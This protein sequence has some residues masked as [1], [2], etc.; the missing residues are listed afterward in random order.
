MAERA[1]PGLAMR[2]G[3]LVLDHANVEDLFRRR[4]C[5]EERPQ[6]SPGTFPNSVEDCPP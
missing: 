5:Y 3:F 4:A 6:V 1:F 2:V